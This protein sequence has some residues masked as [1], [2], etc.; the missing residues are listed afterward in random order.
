ML[1]D[2]AAEVDYELTEIDIR[3]NPEIFEQY[4]Y[5]VPV[6]IVDTHNNMNNTTSTLLEGRIEFRDIA[7][8][9]QQA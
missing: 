3:S 7:K 4:R 5:R 1:D 6:I 9:F 8:A 2:I